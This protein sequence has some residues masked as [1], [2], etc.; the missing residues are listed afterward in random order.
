MLRNRMGCTTARHLVA[1]ILP[2]ERIT[3]NYL[4][5]HLYPI[6]KKFGFIIIVTSLISYFHNNTFVV[7]KFVEEETYK[8]VPLLFESNLAA[9]QVCL[10]KKALYGLKQFRTAW[11]ERFSKVMIRLGYRQSQGVHTLFIKHP[12]SGGV[13]SP[14]VYVDDIIMTGNMKKRDIV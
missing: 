8:E 1:Q 12:N 3:F 2:K 10:L 4:S 6:K 7:A 13:I 14:L 9:K 5:E 11:S